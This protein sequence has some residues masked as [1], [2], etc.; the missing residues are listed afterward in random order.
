M[1]RRAATVRAERVSPTRVAV[2]LAPAGAGHSFPT[3]DM[4]RRAVLTVSTGAARGR[5][6]LT[7]YF[8]QT[9]TDDASGHLLGQ[10]DDT[11]VP[12]PGGGPPPRLDFELDDARA[13]EVAWSLDLFRLSPEDARARGLDEAA[14]GLRVQSGRIAIQPTER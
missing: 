11:R 1:I 12:P 4:F 8:A 9:I 7:R 2:T 3:G 6:V 5:E 13:T 14:R 10:V